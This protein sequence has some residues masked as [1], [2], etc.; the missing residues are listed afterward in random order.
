M[1]CPTDSL[2]IRWCA[3][4]PRAKRLPEAS[5]RAAGEFKVGARASASCAEP[6]WSAS[7]INPRR[8]RTVVA[9][10]E[11]A[12]SAS[13][14]WTSV[15]NTRMARP[16]ARERSKGR[17]AGRAAKPSF[18]SVAVPH[19]DSQRSHASSSA[20]DSSSRSSVR[21]GNPNG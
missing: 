1:A 13:I 9:K 3:S 12:S 19:D 16:S 8:V 7:M 4:S 20:D 21:A 11:V 2:A 6:A 15:S 10:G 18:C 17:L 14:R 5:T